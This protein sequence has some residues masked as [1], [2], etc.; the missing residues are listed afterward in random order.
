MLKPK[1]LTSMKGYKRKQFLSDATA[2]IIVGVVALPLAIAFAIASGVSPE[3]GLFTAVIA[4]FIISALGGSRVQIGGPTGA[5]VVIVYGIVQKYGLDGLTVATIMAGIFLIIMGFARFGSMIKFIPFPVIAGF[6]SGI[7]V[8]IFSSQVHEF[9]GLQITSLPAEFIEKW[10]VYIEKFSSLNPYALIIGLVSLA[11]ILLWQRFSKRIPGALV[12]IIASSLVVYFFKWPVETIGSRFGTI[13]SVIPAPTVPHVSFA[14]VRELIG[15][16]TTIAILAGIEALLSAVVADGMIGGRHRSNM[17]L[18]ANGVANLVT[19]FFGGIPATGA[20]A[21]TATNIKNGGRTPVAGIIHAVVLLLIMLFFGRWASLI[22]LSCLAA[23]L[24]VVAYNMSEWRSFL[25]LLKSPRSDVMVLLATFFLTVLVDLTVA[26]EVGLIM[27]AFLFMR[28]M[29][30]VT[31]IDSI[32]QELEDS[33]DNE[34]NLELANQTVPEGVEVYAINGPLFFGVAHKF[35]EALTTTEKKPFILIVQTQH[36][37]AIDSTGLHTLR[38]IVQ[39]CQKQ[40]ITFI[41][42]GVQEQP[43]EALTQSGLLDR[44]GEA[45]NCGTLDEALDRARQILQTLSH[46][47]MKNEHKQPHVSA[48]S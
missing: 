20:I 46:S 17:E 31:N 10:A 23:I 47:K 44:I 30:M 21:R 29:A 5:F 34:D 12:A 2:G 22:P 33:D 24:M 28:R 42:S 35:E 14:M 16:A 40:N 4:G 39:K 11:I 45:N 9:L 48:Q 7:A 8:I 18:V 38:Q 25:T 3:K 32:T 36:V 37:P 13:A 15:P 41:L 27:A 6:T 43:R 1:I 26:I 19:P